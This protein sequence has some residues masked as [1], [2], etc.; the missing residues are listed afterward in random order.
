M[1]KRAK[2]VS[3]FTSSTMSRGKCVQKLLDLLMHSLLNFK[4]HFTKLSSISRG[5]PT[6]GAEPSV[7]ELQKKSDIS[8]LCTLWNLSDIYEVRYIRGN[9]C[10]SGKAP[11]CP[12]GYGRER[13]LKDRAVSGSKY[14]S[15]PGRPLSQHRVHVRHPWYISHSFIQIMGI[16][17]WIGFFL[18]H[19]LTYTCREPKFSTIRRK[20]SG[21]R[22]ICLEKNLD[23]SIPTACL[24]KRAESVAVFRK[25]NKL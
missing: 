3:I 1:I 7:K 5:T 20:M 17:L 19:P 13:G 22:A 21:I 8:D 6:V 24:Q 16:C 23:T 11:K 25:L 15:R 14:L 10:F 9:F 12:R 4:F 18:V 2:I